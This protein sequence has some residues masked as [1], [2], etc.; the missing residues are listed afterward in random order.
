MQII[1][2]HVLSVKACAWMYAILYWQHLMIFQSSHSLIRKKHTCRTGNEHFPP[3]QTHIL[4][5]I[6][7][8]YFETCYI[9]SGKCVLLTLLHNQVKLNP[10]CMENFGSQLSRV[11]RHL[12]KLVQF[13]RTSTGN[14]CEDQG[15]L[16]PLQPILFISNLHVSNSLADI[17]L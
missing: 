12:D 15:Q 13:S 14:K 17:L 10:L 16:S 6:T 5:K 2:K 9:N 1:K 4:F 7:K 3:F 8:Y 11:Y